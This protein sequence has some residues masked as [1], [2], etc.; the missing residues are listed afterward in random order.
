MML[1]TNMIN[2]NTLK[3]VKNGFIYFEG[4]CDFTSGSVESEIEDA[5]LFDTFEDITIYLTNEN[6]ITL[7][8]LS[9]QKTKI[10]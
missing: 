1:G 4:S 5:V 6:K 8:T 7:L 2:K 9:K 10:V 3:Y